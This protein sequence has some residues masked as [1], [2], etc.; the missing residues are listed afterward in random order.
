[1]EEARMAENDKWMAFYDAQYAMERA[2]WSVLRLT[3]ELLAVV[4]A[5]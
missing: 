2:R 3:G 4:E 1:V 5:Q